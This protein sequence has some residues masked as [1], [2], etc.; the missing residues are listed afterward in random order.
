MLKLWEP[1][2]VDARLLET[3][4]DS[5]T[6]LSLGAPSTLDI[7]YRSNAALKA[8]FEFW[9]SIEVSDY[10]FLS[11]PASC[12]LIV[13]V[14]L[15]SR[16]AKLAGADPI[17]PPMH[18]HSEAVTADC[19]TLKDPSDL[20]KIGDPA[21]SVPK[22]PETEPA[23]VSAIVAI[24]AQIRSQPE[25]K[26]DVMGILRALVTRFES[27]RAEVS[28][29]HGGEWEN[30]I[31]DLAA[32]KISITRLKLER[33]AEIVTAVGPEGLLTGKYQ[34]TEGPVPYNVPAESELPREG[35]M[36]GVERSETVEYMSIQP[37]QDMSS[38][39]NMF[40]N[41][42]FS[43]LGLDQNFFYNEPG[44]YGTAVLNNIA[45]NGFPNGPG[46]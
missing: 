2:I 38:Y 20:P 19:H 18:S 44:D 27:A 6:S 25:L 24:K 40:A 16:W 12:Q 23:V 46:P 45:F 5:F 11:M 22:F 1:P 10:F 4:S 17:D 32:R 13:A 8:W 28:E 31:W 42:L 29:V 7:F 35:P 9:L 41:D 43:G 33:W 36:D 37:G 21:D 30:V 3:L 14:T 15:L 26:L 34:P 39:N